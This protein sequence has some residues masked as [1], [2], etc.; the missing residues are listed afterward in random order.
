[1]YKKWRY[2]K[3]LKLYNISARSKTVLESYVDYFKDGASQIMTLFT[4][5]KLIHL[6]EY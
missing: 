3:N 5:Q 2:E 1:M 6:I 4:S